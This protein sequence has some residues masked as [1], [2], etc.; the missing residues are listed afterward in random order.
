M[1]LKY[2]KRLDKKENHLIEEQDADGNTPLHLATINW[3][4]RTVMDLTK[5]SSNTT[6]IQNVENKDGLRPLDIAELKLQPYYVFREVFTNHDLFFSL[7]T[8]YMH[9]LFIH[10]F[11]SS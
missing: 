8:I 1:L 5:F 7:Y 3:R 4:P 11:S 6:K 9:F 2:I 10:F